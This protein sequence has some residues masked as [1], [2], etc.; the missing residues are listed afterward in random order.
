[1]EIRRMLPNLINSNLY[2]EFYFVHRLD[3]VTSGV[4]CIAL[5]KQSARAASTSFQ[6]RTVEKYYLALVHG[7]I[8]KPSMIINVLIGNDLREV[9]GNRKM[10]TIDNNFCKKPQKSCTALLVLE[11]G[12]RNKEAVTKILLYP[13]TGRRHQL[14]VHCTHIGH[15]IVGDY[16]YS[17]KTDTEPYRTFLHALRLTINNTVEYLD[18]RSV[19]PFTSSNS[20][21]QWKPSK[22]LRILDESAFSDIK[23][24]T[25]NT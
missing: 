17:E 19:D 11:K 14:R 22:I 1:M 13:V 24:L 7:H 3:Y 16:T 12:Y 5:N 10:C 4:M 23:E 6:K 20:Q 15:I 18:V 21:N 2:H 25:L 9:N 8:N